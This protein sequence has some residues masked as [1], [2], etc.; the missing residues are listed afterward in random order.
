[1]FSTLT[2]NFIAVGLMDEPSIEIWDLDIV[3]SSWILV[4]L[5]RFMW[6][7]DGNVIVISNIFCCFSDWWSATM[8]DIGWYCWE[9]KKERKE[10]SMLNSFT[11][12]AFDNRA[13]LFNFL[14]QFWNFLCIRYQSNTKKTVTEIQFSGL[15]GIRSTGL[16]SSRVLYYLLLLQWK[17]HKLSC[18]FL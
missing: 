18:P 10:G 12:W 4:S 1:M 9:E 17:V 5:H 2:G 11:V 7:I 13:T 3:C 8:R 15:L 6:V 14:Y 16:Y